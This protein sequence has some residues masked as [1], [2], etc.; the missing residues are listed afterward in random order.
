MKKLATIDLPSTNAN[1]FEVLARCQTAAK[2]AGAER[3]RIQTFLEDAV[4]G[5]YE[6]LLRVV[7][8]HFEISSAQT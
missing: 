5:D 6:H 2:K 4:Q 3:A 7:K 1:A 8:T